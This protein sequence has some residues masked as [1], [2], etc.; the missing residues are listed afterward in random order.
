MVELTETTEGDLKGWCLA[1][2]DEPPVSRIL[3]KWRIPGIKTAADIPNAA[4]VLV[5][6]WDEI[7]RRGGWP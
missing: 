7:C 2:R 1:D 4:D 6:V 5:I 3:V